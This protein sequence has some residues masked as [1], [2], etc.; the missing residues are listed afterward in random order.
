MATDTRGADGDTSDATLGEYGR[1]VGVL[2]GRLLQFMALT[3]AAVAVVVPVAGTPAPWALV[4][5]IPLAVVLLLFV[6]AVE[7]GVRTLKDD[8]DA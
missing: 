1:F 3:F 2:L 8:P 6:L 7:V 5:L 4:A